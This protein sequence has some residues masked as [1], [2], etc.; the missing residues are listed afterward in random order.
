M[1]ESNGGWQIEALAA[2]KTN[3][4]NVLPESQKKG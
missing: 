4:T 2:T 3:I 1:E